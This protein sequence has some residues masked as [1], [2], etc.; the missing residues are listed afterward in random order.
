MEPGVFWEAP[1]ATAST[2]ECGHFRAGEPLQHVH[3]RRVNVSRH[4]ASRMY[5]Y[6][7]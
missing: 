6:R 2:D 5:F 4:R 7:D 1:K 3:A